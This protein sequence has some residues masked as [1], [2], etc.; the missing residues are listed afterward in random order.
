[1]TSQQEKELQPG[2]IGQRLIE[3]GYLTKEQL[4]EALLAQKETALLLGEVCMLRGWLTIEQLS[5][6]LRPARSKLGTKLLQ[7]GK[8]TIDQLWISLLEQR[9]TG[10]RLGEILVSRGWI[11]EETLKSL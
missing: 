4:H 3:A 5:H 7:A 11:D 2:L 6:C 1:M 10:A 8:I 9:H